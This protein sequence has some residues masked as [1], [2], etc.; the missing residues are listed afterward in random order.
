M[1][2][3]P[4]LF[5]RSKLAIAKAVGVHR[6]TIDA[7]VEQI[8]FPKATPDGWLKE[9]VLRAVES[10]NERNE[11]TPS[12]DVAEGSKEEKTALE[13]ARLKIVIEKELELL[14]QAKEDTRR[15]IEEGKRTSRKL[16]TK[17]EVEEGLTEFLSQLR[18]VIQ[19]WAK[20]AQADLPE[21]HAVFDRAVK[22]YLD[23]V[24]KIGGEI[25]R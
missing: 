9:E 13:C 3:Q 21:H 2:S 14:E 4:D 5:F 12:G 6:H 16:I 7:W 22:L 23:N 10:Y 1:K 20:S 24:Q 17:K 11:A 19:S 8:W 18:S 25:V 15:M